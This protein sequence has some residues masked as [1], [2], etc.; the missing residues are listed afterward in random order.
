MKEGVARKIRE[1]G[2]EIYAISSEPQ[3]LA[4]RAVAEWGLDFESVGDPHHEIADACR[5]KGWLDLFVNERLEFLQRSASAHGQTDWEV[6][7]P[8]GFFQ[9]GVLALTRAGRVL[10]RWRGVPT[11]QN[12]GGATERPTADHVWSRVEGSLGAGEHAADAA[13]DEDP[14]LDMRGVPWPVFSSL[15]IANGW[16]MNARGFQGP[17]MIMMAAV[18]L[19]A[20]VA[21]WIAAF[22]WLPTLPVAIAL[23]AWVAFIVPTFRW[24]GEQFQDVSEAPG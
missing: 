6:T 19:V 24:V 3:A 23:A 17:R 8:K 15:L 16:F 2:G 20:F 7:H 1:A 4:T 22:V 10:Y 5:D 12:M 13:L 9:P 21:A 11:H 14:P 18:R